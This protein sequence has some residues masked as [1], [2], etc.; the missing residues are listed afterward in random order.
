[1]ASRKSKRFGGKVRFE[2][3][4]LIAAR[5]IAVNLEAALRTANNKGYVDGLFD[6]HTVKHKFLSGAECVAWLVGW[7]QGQV[8]LHEQRRIAIE[9]LKEI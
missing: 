7:R 6:R 4:E 5:R 8:E 1:M 9:I 2:I 3:Q